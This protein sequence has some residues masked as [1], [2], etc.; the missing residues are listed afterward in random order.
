MNILWSLSGGKTSSYMAYMASKHMSEHNNL[1]VFANTGEEHEKTLEFMHNVDQWL[2]LGLVW[3]EAV[4]N[5]A[6]ASSTHKVVDYASASRKG[7]PFEKV[8]EKYGIPNQDW[9]H[10]NRELKLNPIH[11]LASEYFNGEPY[12]T[13][14]GIRVDE[15]ARIGK[16]PDF[17]YPLASEWAVD[18]QDVN[19]FWES[20]SF[21]LE[22]PEHHGNCKTCWKKSDR[23]LFT[24]ASENPE[25]FDFF[26]R[27]ERK[28]G[29]SGYFNNESDPDRVFF[30]GYRTVDDIF[31]AAE[32]LGFKKFVQDNS[33][34][35]KLFGYNL[36]ADGGCTESCEAY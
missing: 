6:G 3:I 23:K 25:W 5:E 30:R 35:R 12:K 7:E 11:S 10:C 36:D 31:L 17:F 19:D 1:F 4:V 34:Q 8:I 14:I 29:R 21:T 9:K 20:Q 13:A 18:K 15:P 32:T 26:K 27:M 28:H 2:G 33:Y 16:N 22:I 24:I